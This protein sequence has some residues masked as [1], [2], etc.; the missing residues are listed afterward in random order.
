MTDPT[1][2]AEPAPAI[3][4]WQGNGHQPRQ[5]AGL[6]PTRHR[7]AKTPKPPK[8]KR[9]VP[10]LGTRHVVA[11][12]V[13]V[14]AVAVA[15]TVQRMDRPVVVQQAPVDLAALDAWSQQLRAEIRAEQAPTVVATMALA[16]LPCPLT[17]EAQTMIG[18]DPA[19]GY[20]SLNPQRGGG[21]ET[22]VRG[23]LAAGVPLA[24]MRL[25]ADPPPALRVVD[26]G[27]A[28]TALVA[29]E[30]ATPTTTVTAAQ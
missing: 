11:A 25:L 28:G 9:E 7:Q 21:V 2:I 30:V 13:V 12:V 29:C 1:P 5:P 14:S 27:A 6:N 24:R 16:W 19:T 20:T 3:P 26:G 17:G 4:P 10:K 18:M 23:L 15:W 8:W 22:Q